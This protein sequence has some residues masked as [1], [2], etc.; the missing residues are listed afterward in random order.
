ME[1]IHR[2]QRKPIIQMTM[3]GE[4]IREW[5]ISIPHTSLS[6]LTARVF[7]VPAVRYGMKTCGGYRWKF[8]E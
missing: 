2:S 5:P 4:F 1:Q 6:D 3:D 7:R 8:K